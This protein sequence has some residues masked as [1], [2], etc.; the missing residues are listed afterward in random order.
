MY[1]EHPFQSYKDERLHG[2]Y[3]T[4]SHLAGFLSELPPAKLS[5]LGYSV[6]QAPLYGIRL[7][8]GSTRIFMW[9]QMHGNESTTTKAVVD[10]MRLVQGDS[11]LSVEL[12][13]HFEFFILPLVNPDG[14]ERYTRE[15]A[16]GVDLNRDAK[17]CSQPESVV[18]RKAFED[19]K[20]HYCFNLHD[21]RTI[22]GAGTTGNPATV[23]FLAPAFNA[24][25]EF[26]ATRLKAVA[27]INAMNAVLQ[28]Y[29]P[30]RIGRFDD[31]F[32]DNCIGDTFQLLGVPTILVE[33]GHFPQ[34]YEREKTRKFIFIALISGLK[35]IYEIDLVRNEIEDYMNIPQ[36]IPNFYDFVYKNIRIY[37][38]GSKIISNFAAQY[39]EVLIDKQIHWKAYISKVGL[40]DAYQ[41]HTTY[42]CQDQEFFADGISAPVEGD[43]ATFNLSNGVRF[44]NGVRIS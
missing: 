13:T 24:A 41:G 37:C 7:G 28:R 11:E 19:F 12:R 29:I 20:P 36:N 31:S 44:E 6:A 27:V 25:C 21:Q 8:N 3:I 26:N 33:A 9:S 35:S 5:I 43:E 2:R 40:L 15:N 16:N 38:D 42:D 34:D 14:A 10:F 17:L 18:L 22:F 30:N 4:L 23:S 39:K 1:Y 32:N